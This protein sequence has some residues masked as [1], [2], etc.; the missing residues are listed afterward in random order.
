GE[1]MGRKINL[2]WTDMVKGQA[3]GKYFNLEQVKKNRLRKWYKENHEAAEQHYPENDGSG[4]GIN[5]E[6]EDIGTLEGE[7]LVVMIQPS[8]WGLGKTDYPEKWVFTWVEDEVIIGCRPLGAHHGQF[9]YSVLE[10]EMDG[11][12]LLKRGI[13]QILEPMND[14]LNWLINTHFF[15]IRRT[16][17]DN[18][19]VD[20][21]RVVMKDLMN[22]K[23]GKII[24]LKEAAYGTDVRTIVSQLDV[25]D[26]TNQHLADTRII[27]DLAQK[28]VGVN[29]NIMGMIHQGGRKTATEI[30]TSSS[31][32]IN[33]LKTNSEW[34]SAGG[35]YDN[36]SQML[37]NTQQYYD[38]D[39]I[40]KLSG[41]LG[42][43][44]VD[45]QITPDD[46]AG[47][48]DFVPVDGTLP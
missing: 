5:L 42:A 11:G 22:N 9:P 17:N 23:A 41:E 8:K 36:V 3:D 14:T 37:A 33:R 24:R 7:E 32:G 29:D 43:E 26:V 6:M 1:F 15:N 21:G 10:Y 20:P 2:T 12:L 48:F 28:M 46:I 25:H 47:Q 35:W 4:V 40:F 27:E 45:M 16:L 13:H 34:F 19:I 39:Q 31:F 38:D 44:L 18:L 30:R